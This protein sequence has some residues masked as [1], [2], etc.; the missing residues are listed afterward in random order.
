MPPDNPTTGSPEPSSISG[1]LRAV[2]QTMEASGVDAHAL[3]TQ[4]GIETSIIDNPDARVPVRNMSR[5]WRLMVEATGDEAIALRAVEY[6][7]SSAVYG[8]DTLWEAA[9]TIRER[10]RYLER[11][12]PVVSTGME[13]IV[14]ELPNGH[15][16]LKTTPNLAEVV[17]ESGDCL[18]ANLVALLRSATGQLSVLKVR[19]P[20][21]EPG[22]PA[23]FERLLGCP[24]EYNAPQVT[25]HIAVDVPVD[26]PLASANP[27]L[28][29]ALA[30]V[31]ADYLERFNKTDLADQVRHRIMARLAEGEPTLETVAKDLNMSARTLQRKLVA[32]GSGFR[33]LVDEVRCNMAQEL[34]ADRELSVIDIAYQL[35]FRDASNFS[36][37]F[38]RWTGLSPS[39]FRQ[40]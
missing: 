17:W 22:N 18:A 34:M 32:A 35:G 23:E 21:P 26:Q 14:E 40:P 13:L 36:R 16:V 12:V 15:F 5:L 11:F 28:A 19:L 33:P 7:S 39:E 2:V 3:L 25:V 27:K 8:L 4:A 31:L 29:Q 38:R 6:V 10:L 24:V 20:R 9:P 1:W 30:A 37:V